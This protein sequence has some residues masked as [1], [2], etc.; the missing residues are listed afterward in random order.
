MG[1]SKKIFNWENIFKNT[2]TFQNNKP[3]PFGFVEEV[4]DRTFYEKLFHSF[5]QEDDKW[6]N[7]TDF[8]RSAKK[9]WFGLNKN[10]SIAVDDED[11]NLSKEWNEFHHYLFSRE[12]IENISAHTGIKLTGLRQF[13]FISTHMGDF[14]MPHFHW[15]GSQKGK[16]SYKVTFLMYFSKGF[17]KGDAGGTYVCANEDESSIIFEPYNLDN[18]MVGFAET[19]ISWHGSRY[20]TKDLVRHSIQ[21]TFF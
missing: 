17:K 15:E 9:R 3:F 6:H 4:L 16:E 18:S 20:M 19:A 7:V 13:G 5:P 12:V 21:F 8:S 10:S 2:E 1:N 14:S 11:P